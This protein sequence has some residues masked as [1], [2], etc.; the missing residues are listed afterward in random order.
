[1]K[2]RVIGK[3]P[4][5]QDAGGACSGYLIEHAGSN[6]LLDCG[7]GVFGKLREAVDYCSVGDVLISHMHGDHMLDLVP[8]AYGLLYGP[9]EPGHAVNLWLPPGGIDVMRTICGAFGSEGL[10]EEAFTV[11]EYD[12]DAALAVGQLKIDFRHVPHF[13]DAW[14][15]RIAEG[16]SRF[17]FGADCG[18]SDRLREFAA[19][20]DLLILEATFA[21]DAAE[22]DG[23]MTPAQ[24]GLL[25]R[26]A[27]A[28]RLVLTH[29]SDCLD[30]E[31]SRRAAAEVFGEAVA[32]AAAGDIW[33]V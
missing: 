13:I 6:L 2:I 7:N 12:P 26:D 33:Q 8:F 4:A 17:V 10:I 16:E 9:T 14:A 23:H 27:N 19:G 30:L 5:W 1:M 11:A 21:H 31:A 3:S 20:A 29:V 22:A 28:A 25:A 15:V 32:V 18:P 24:A